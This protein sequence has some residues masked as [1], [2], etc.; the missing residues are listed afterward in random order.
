MCLTP[1]QHQRLFGRNA[2]TG[3]RIACGTQACVFDTLD[4]DKVVKVTNDVQDIVFLKR[5]QKTGAVV[6]VF[7]AFRLKG[8]PRPVAAA[9]VERLRPLDAAERRA[10][11]RALYALPFGAAAGRLAPSGEPFQRSAVEAQ[12]RRD[13]DRDA[14]GCDS[15]CDRI[16]RGLFDVLEAV[17]R[18]G[19]VWKDVAPQNVGVDANGR[20]KALDVGDHAEEPADE[21]PLAGVRRRTRVQRRQR[22]RRH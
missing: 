15:T 9:V 6:R 11:D 2:P 19:V 3:A 5:L 10:F 4:S 22:Q 18:T 13:L 8:Q 7:R 14:H 21:L 17:T 20:L 12:V 16:V 1:A